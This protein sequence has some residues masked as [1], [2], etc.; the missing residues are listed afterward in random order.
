MKAG[1]ENIWETHPGVQ[2]ETIGVGSD[3][4]F[5]RYREGD[6]RTVKSDPYPDL[7]ERT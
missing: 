2:T 1:A 7:S 5:H 4:F 3:G 6:I